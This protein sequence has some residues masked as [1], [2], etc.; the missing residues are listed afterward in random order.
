MKN[1]DDSHA[2]TTDLKVKL[3]LCFA[4]TYFQPVTQHYK[5]RTVLEAPLQSKSG[6]HI[7][8]SHALHYCESTPWAIKIFC[9]GNFCRLRCL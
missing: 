6:H 5:Q 2:P 4:F 9:R 3:P 1:M 8:Y 7:K